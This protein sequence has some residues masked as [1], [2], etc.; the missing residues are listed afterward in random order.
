MQD[1]NLMEQVAMYMVALPCP[2]LPVKVNVENFCEKNDENE[3]VEIKESVCSSHDLLAGVLICAMQRKNANMNNERKIEQIQITETLIE[4]ILT[5][6]SSKVHQ[7]G[8]ILSVKEEFD[9]IDNKK[10]CMELLFDAFKKFT[11][12]YLLSFDDKNTTT[13]GVQYL[14]F[15]DVNIGDKIHK[16]CC[17]WLVAQDIIYS[18][19]KQNTNDDCEVQSCQNPTRDISW[20]ESYSYEDLIFLHIFRIIENEKNHMTSEG[21]Q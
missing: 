5:I 4:T 9:K 6:Y 7:K 3:S 11:A 19:H 21:E 15:N 12:E 20:F 16:A 13:P 2:P 8:S 18:K 1:P 10:E 14:S 17:S